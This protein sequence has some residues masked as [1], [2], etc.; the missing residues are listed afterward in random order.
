VVEEAGVGGCR[1]RME[2]SCW[3]QIRRDSRPSEFRCV[4]LALAAGMRG[5]YPWLAAKTRTKPA[6]PEQRRCPRYASIRP[7]KTVL[8]LAMPA[9]GEGVTNAEWPQGE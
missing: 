9:T 4:G 2:R 1:G 5:C 7:E 8:Q 6:D 3:V